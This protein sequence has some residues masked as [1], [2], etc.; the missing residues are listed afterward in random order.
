M[1]I[2]AGR[3][4]IIRLLNRMLNHSKCFLAIEDPYA[5][6]HQMLSTSMEAV[7]KL[8]IKKKKMETS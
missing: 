4:I 3:H 6:S 7:N 5:M 1:L 2:I 8:V